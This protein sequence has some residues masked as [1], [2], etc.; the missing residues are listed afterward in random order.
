MR[1][2]RASI[3]QTTLPEESKA[4]LVAAVNQA[5]YIFPESGDV[6]LVLAAVNA[7]L[8]NDV[9][10]ATSCLQK[11]KSVKT[12]LVCSNQSFIILRV[13]SRIFTT[14]LLPSGT[15]Q[16]RMQPARRTGGM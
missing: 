1:M 8:L 5:S 16:A 11:A 12:S 4:G 9:H 13:S 15:K 10:T 3:G 6:T 14:L 7:F 2:L